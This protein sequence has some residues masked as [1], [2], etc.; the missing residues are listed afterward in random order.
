MMM[1]R[2]YRVCR[3]LSRWRRGLSLSRFLSRNGSLPQFISLSIPL[4]RFLSRNG[5]L[6]Q[7]NHFSLS[8]SRFLSRND[9]LPL[10]RSALLRDVTRGGSC[11]RPRC[12]RPPLSRAFTV[13]VKSYTH[14]IVTIWYRAPEQWVLRRNLLILLIQA[15]MILLLHISRFVLKVPEEDQHSFQRILF[16][17]KYAY[18]VFYV[19]VLFKMLCNGIKFLVLM[20]NLCSC[21]LFLWFFLSASDHLLLCRGLI[22]R[23]MSRTDTHAYVTL[24][25]C[26]LTGHS[27]F[28]LTF[29]LVY[30]VT[31]ILSDKLADKLARGARNLPSAM[32][33]VDSIPPRWLTGLES[34]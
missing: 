18:C 28:Y 27:L 16:L 14:E 11:Q 8:L 29:T 22:L 1:K 23:H 15:M 33:Y 32:V 25:E 20:S 21:V 7:F 4:S 12:R 31:C 24:Y 34:A 19:V 10:G 30:Y 17:V 6:P 2:W 26:V 13:P 3:K 5:S 9:S